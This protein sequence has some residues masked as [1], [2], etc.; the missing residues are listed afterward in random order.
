MLSYCISF[1]HALWSRFHF[2]NEFPVQFWMKSIVLYKKKQKKRNTFH[3]GGQPLISEQKGSRK[4]NIF[5]WS[6]QSLWGLTNHFFGCS[7]QKQKKNKFGKK[8]K[9]ILGQGVIFH[10]F[11]L[12]KRFYMDWRSQLDTTRSQKRSVYLAICLFCRFYEE[13]NFTWESKSSFTL[14]VISLFLL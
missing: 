1:F 10:F 11:Y 3:K 12:E 14:A 2:F 8:L 9:L 5:F 4:K 7:V 6:Q 13:N